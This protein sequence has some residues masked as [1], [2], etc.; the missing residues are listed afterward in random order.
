MNLDSLVLLGTAAAFG[1]VLLLIGVAQSSFAERRTIN[2]SL[3]AV[4]SIHLEDRADLG[5]KRLADPA[6]RRVLAPAMRRLSQAI[7]RITP[8][9][10]VER[11]D[12]ELAQ[13]GSP[14]AWDVGRVLAMKVIVPTALVIAAFPFADVV[15]VGDVGAIALATGCGLVGW[16]LP[17]WVIRSR[18]QVRQAEVQRS[19]PDR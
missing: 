13:L 2:R 12:L 10:T 9:G 17:E 16:H 4:R 14:Q 19:M 6:T 3:R 8:V 7:R 5:K 1:A 11:I 18:A 15:G